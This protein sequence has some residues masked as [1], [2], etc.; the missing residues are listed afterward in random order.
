MEEEHIFRR[1]YIVRFTARI[2]PCMLCLTAG[3]LRSPLYGEVLRVTRSFAVFLGYVVW[4]TV[5]GKRRT[6]A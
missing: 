5:W 4:Q 6:A 1:I 2:A 3:K